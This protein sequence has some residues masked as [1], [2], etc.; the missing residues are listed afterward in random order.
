MDWRSWSRREKALLRDLALMLAV[1]LVVG[2]YCLERLDTRMQVQQRQHLQALAAYL[3]EDGAEYLSAGN[4]VSLGVIA[5]KA[6][7]LDTVA[8]LVVRDMQGRVLARSGPEQSGPAPVQQAAASGQ[9]PVGRVDVWPAADTAAREGVEAGFVLVVLLLLALRVLGEIMRRQLGAEGSGPEPSEESD[10]PDAS[11]R[12][13]SAPSPRVR[14]GLRVEPDRLASLHERYTRSALKARLAEHES[15]LDRV[16][17]LYGGVRETPLDEGARVLFS[18]ERASEAAFQALC[19][20]QVFLR[21]ARRVGSADDKRA[22]AFRVLLSADNATRV[23]IPEHANT[24]V[25]YVPA[26]ELDGLELD[27]CALY[28]HEDCLDVNTE[29]GVVSLQPVAQLVQRYQHLVATQADR[30]AA[31]HA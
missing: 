15:L 5:R 17:T 1:M 4:H 25:V 10:E 26:Q 3:A 28:R 22:P 11:P 20:A 23:G 24:G 18:D 12:P 14:V 7:E 19:A 31:G 2:V 9:G 29:T 30:L 16:V 21:A 13:E 27:Q 8:T 6:V